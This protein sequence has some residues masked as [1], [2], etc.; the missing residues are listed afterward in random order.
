[1]VNH[2]SRINPQPRVCI[3]LLIGSKEWFFFTL[4]RYLPLGNQL[5]L[6][7]EA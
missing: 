6:L 3:C 1:M 4:L 5:S 2:A 7:P